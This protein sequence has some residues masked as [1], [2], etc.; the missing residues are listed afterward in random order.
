MSQIEWKTIEIRAS[1]VGNV[2]PVSCP[3]YDGCDYL[4]DVHALNLDTLIWWRCCTAAAPNA[5]SPRTGHAAAAA[6]LDWDAVFVFG[7]AGKG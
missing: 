7:G 1:K 5:P 4:N 6:P 3:G 2:S